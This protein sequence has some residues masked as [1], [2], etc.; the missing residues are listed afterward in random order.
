MIFSGQR[1]TNGS[2][3]TEQSEL[4]AKP[5]LTQATA[6]TTGAAT[7]KSAAKSTVVLA[8]KPAQ[9]IGKPVPSSIVTNWQTSQTTGGSVPRP[10]G[11]WW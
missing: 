3:G 10:A 2:V 11:S 1:M 4:V 8:V 9:Q 5:P 7:T 6:V